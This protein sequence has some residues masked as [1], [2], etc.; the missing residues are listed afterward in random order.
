M[1]PA[2][3]IDESEGQSMRKTTVFILLFGLLLAVPGSHETAQAA[4]GQLIRIATL[5][6]RGSEL[7]RGF[8]KIN[9][10]MKKAT[11]GAWGIR[12]YPSGV[13]GDEKD[14]IRKMRVNQMD[15]STITTTG[16]SQIVREVAVLDTP[17]VVRNYKEVERVQAVMNKEWEETFRK[18]GFELLA[19][20]ETGEYRY[21]S[22][23]P[24]R[25]P[26]DLKTMRPWVWPESHVLKEIYRSIGATGVPLGVP[27]VYGAL[28]TGMIDS[29]VGTALA[30]VALQWH[31]KLEYV[32]KDTFGVLLGA[33]VMTSE[34]WKSIPKDVQAIVHEEIR[35]NTEGDRNNVRKTDKSA[36]KKLLKRGYKE[37]SYTP[38]GKKA[39]E[40]MAL[41]VR[42]RLAGRIYPKAL[43]DRVIKIARGG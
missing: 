8:A 6:P 21:F 41:D 14:V 43:L 9:A 40:A 10:N 11:K 3:E 1:M 17:G 7:T 27:E 38:E 36:Y 32:T 29:L 22:K 13:A 28:Q 2:V 37:T 30:T 4:K 31:T 24:I 23:K 25:H 19:W 12:L 35:K 5:A 42:K 16:L 18:K 39:Y 33:M 20:G 34:K 15:A 26:N